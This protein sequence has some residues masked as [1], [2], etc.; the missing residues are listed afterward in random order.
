MGNMMA[1]RLDGY[2]RRHFFYPS[3]S[4]FFCL[5]LLLCGCG[6]REGL[7]PVVE[8]N[9]K[10]AS[11]RPKQHVV[12]RGETLYAIAFRYD[13]DYRRLAAINHLQSPYLLQVGQ[14][15][16]L[17]QAI[18]PSRKTKSAKR[19]T[20][21]Y[22]PKPVVPSK[23]RVKPQVLAQK[24]TGKTRKNSQM[25]A[26]PG[27]WIWPAQGK[28]MTYYAP[29]LGKKGIDIAGKKGDKI[30]A[31]RGGIVAYAG[32]GLPGYGNLIIIKHG[33]H[34]LTA[35]ANNLRNLVKEGETVRAGQAIA[36]M[37][38][39]GRRF[40]GLHFEIRKAGKPVNPLNHLKLG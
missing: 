28:V 39:V 15:I 21:P 33:D 31:A 38:L 16:K 32:D 2:H 17:I 20:R 3:V 27:G 19:I 6:Q 1:C 8:L 24:A 4:M 34:Y 12:R 29:L 13:L 5:A 7:A 25:T 9:W 23:N 10:T 30:H 22:T 36:E 37:G 35:Y 11:I 26:Q 40:W 18:E 14:K